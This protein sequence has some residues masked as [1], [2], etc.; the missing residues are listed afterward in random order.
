MKSV[1]KLNGIF[2]MEK[3]ICVYSKS[4]KQT[5]NKKNRRET[6]F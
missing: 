4:N 1:M 6:F 5:A 3:T 2:A